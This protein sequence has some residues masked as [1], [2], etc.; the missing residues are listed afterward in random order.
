MRV[1]LM[2]RPYSVKGLDDFAAG[3]AFSDSVRSTKSTTTPAG[4]TQIWSL[5]RQAG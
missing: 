4:E 1:S 3:D 5:V 2:E